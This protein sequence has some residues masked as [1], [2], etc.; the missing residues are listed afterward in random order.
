MYYIGGYEKEIRGNRIYHRIQIGDSAIVEKVDDNPETINYTLRDQLG[1][2]IATV[3]DTGT[4]KR[5]FY[6][7]WG[8]RLDLPVP[9]AQP[10][11][12]F[13]LAT[14]LTPR[15]FTGHEH[16]DNVGLIHMNGRVYD[17]EIARFVSADPLIPSPKNLQSYNRYSY[18]VN[19]PLR[20]TAPSGFRMVDAEHTGN[21]DDNNESDSRF[22]RESDRDNNSGSSNNKSGSGSSATKE[23]DGS[24]TLEMTVSAP[25][26]NDDNDRRNRGDNSGYSQA[27]ATQAAVEAQRNA[28]LAQRASNLLSTVS[29]YASYAATAALLTGFVP[30]AGALA[31]VAIIAGIFA[32]GVDIAVNGKNF[33]LTSTAGAALSTSYKIAGDIL[34]NML[35]GI[36]RQPARVVIDATSQVQGLLMNEAAKNEERDSN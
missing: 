20:Y 27:A 6:D 32:V 12:L 25:R 28:A 5:L 26:Y 17:P 31:N 10:L 3:S 19:N 16:L 29:R 34:P 9:D 4:I 2:L 15:G 18:T 24:V 33:N 13:N 11:T 21:P 23:A 22:G 8:K 1:S 36:A 7:P 30:V 14:F 35:P